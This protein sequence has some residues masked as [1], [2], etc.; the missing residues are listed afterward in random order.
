[1]IFLS[2][3]SQNKNSLYFSISKENQIEVYQS[4]INENEPLEF[5]LN[6]SIELNTNAKSIMEELKNI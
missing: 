3:F 2:K 4:Y 5:K 6:E 1:M